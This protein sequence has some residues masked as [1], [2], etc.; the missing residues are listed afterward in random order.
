MSFCLLPKA[1][2]LTFPNAEHAAITLQQ[3]PQQVV[4]EPDTCLGATY[5][6][7]WWNYL[8]G[9][10]RADGTTVTYNRT[11]LLPLVP[12]PAATHLTSQFGL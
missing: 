11:P 8:Q 10:A 1:N 9:G 4:P 6:L 12:V 7:S 2:T 3:L 5:L